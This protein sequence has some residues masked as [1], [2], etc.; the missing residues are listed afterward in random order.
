MALGPRA[1]GNWSSLSFQDG[2]VGV[3]DLIVADLEY[4]YSIICYILYFRVEK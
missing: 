1:R 4:T 2:D 3:A